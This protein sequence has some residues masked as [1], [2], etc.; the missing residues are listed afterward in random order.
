[1][2]RVGVRLCD[3]KLR[4]QLIHQKIGPHRRRPRSLR[5]HRVGVRLCGRKLR[6]HFIH[7]KLG[8]P[9]RPPRLFHLVARGR[10]LGLELKACPLRTLV[11]LGPSIVGVGQSA[12]TL[13]LSPSGHELRVEVARQRLQSLYLVGLTLLNILLLPSGLGLSLQGRLL[14]GLRKVGVCLRS[15]LL[16]LEADVVRQPRLEG[17]AGVINALVEADEG[18]QVHEHQLAHRREL[19]GTEGLHEDPHEA[20]AQDGKGLRDRSHR[21]L[22]ALVRVCLLAEMA[23]IDDVEASLGSGPLRRSGRNGPP[24][25]ALHRS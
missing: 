22:A 19:L 2:Q 21:H 7:Q 20:H 4:L 1:L 24:S 23:R 13:E 11:I 6:P 9:R 16:E 17:P 10:E 3:R 14:Q 8:P 12:Q 25:G 5:L 15:A 18:P